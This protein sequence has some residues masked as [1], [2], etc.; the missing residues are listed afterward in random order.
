M[1]CHVSASGFFEIFLFFFLNFFLISFWFFINFF[2]IFKKIKILPRVK[3]SKKIQKNSKKIQKKNSKK[4]SKN[5]K[6]N[7]KKNRNW[8]VALTLTPFG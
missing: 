6:K 2:K 3:N 4:N 7:K 1:G 8:H 5:I